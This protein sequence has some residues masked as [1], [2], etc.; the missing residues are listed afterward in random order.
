MYIGKVDSMEVAFIVTD[1]QKVDY[2]QVCATMRDTA[3]RER[4]LAPLQA[5]EDNYPKT[6]LTLDPDP[7]TYHNGIKQQNAIDWLLDCQ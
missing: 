1:M 2:Y 7:V 5:I 4:E 6:I 3:T